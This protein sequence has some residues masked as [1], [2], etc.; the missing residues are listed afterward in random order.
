MIDIEALGLERPEAGGLLINGKTV[1]ASVLAEVADGARALA[2]R[3]VKPGLAVV[4]VGEDPASQVYVRSKGKAAETCGFH[5]LQHTL[6]ATTSE[7]VLLS[8]VQKLNADPAIHGIL[9]DRK[10]TR[11]N[12]SHT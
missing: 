11:L 2:A 4:L 5:S 12:S 7:A 10:S 6:P 3:G 1:S 9:I 8:L